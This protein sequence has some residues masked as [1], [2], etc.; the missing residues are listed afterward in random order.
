MVAVAWG[1]DPVDVV[2]VVATEPN[3]TEVAAEPN[4]TGEAVAPVVVVEAED[5]MEVESEDRVRV[6][7]GVLEEAVPAVVCCI[8]LQC[9]AVCCSVQQ[10]AAVCWQ[11]Y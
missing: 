1:G 3:Q 2:A 4:G 6:A 10:C 11:Q 8:V 9:A 5:G 7:L